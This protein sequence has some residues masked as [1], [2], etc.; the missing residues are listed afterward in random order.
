[1]N[2]LLTLAINKL[3]HDWSHLNW[4]FRDLELEDGTPDKM[5]QWQG[6]SEEDIMI[7]AFKGK[8]ISEPFHRQDFFHAL[9]PPSGCSGRSCGR[10]HPCVL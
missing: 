1:M 3:G 4:E 8:H 7:V 10:A 2:K 5:S 9:Y 6:D